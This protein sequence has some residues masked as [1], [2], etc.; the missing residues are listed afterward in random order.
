MKLYL[1]GPMSGRPQLNFPAFHK[2]AQEL[3]E[4][5]YEVVNPAELDE[6]AGV[7]S[8]TQ[9]VTPEMR[10]AAMLRDL[11]LLLACDAIAILPGSDN[12]GGVFVESVVANYIPM[13]FLMIKYEEDG[14][15]DLREMFPSGAKLTAEAVRNGLWS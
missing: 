4:L 9:E 14:A 13:P 10:R 11:P 7:R 2:A 8:D 3:R 6:Q 5:G 1:A 12:S 15:I